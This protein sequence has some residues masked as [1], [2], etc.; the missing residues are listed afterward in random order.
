MWNSGFVFAAMG[1]RNISLLLGC[2]LLLTVAT[3]K[4]GVDADD[5]DVAVSPKTGSHAPAE[6]PTTG[7]EDDDNEGDESAGSDQQVV[8]SAETQDSDE[9]GAVS[10]RRTD[11]TPPPPPHSSQFCGND[12][13]GH[14]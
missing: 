4:A 7:A 3:A 12:A 11:P 9:E 2:C 5:D 1:I 13:V 14:L 8:E 6:Q 10:V